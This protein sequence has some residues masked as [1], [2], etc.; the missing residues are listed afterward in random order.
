MRFSGNQQ[1]AGLSEIFSISNPKPGPRGQTSC[2]GRPYDRP[3]RARPRN[4]FPNP[5]IHGKS[6]AAK[7]PFLPAGTQ[8]GGLIELCPPDTGIRGGGGLLIPP[9]SPRSRPCVTLL[10]AE[11]DVTL[12]LTRDARN[13]R[14]VTPG[15]NS[16]PGCLNIVF[17]VPPLLVLLLSGRVRKDGFRSVSYTHLT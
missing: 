3:C 12:T 15:R 1:H 4:A 11:R 13:L 10:T 5:A 8:P 16:S 2:R 6:R 14:V 17:L 7:T 9:Q